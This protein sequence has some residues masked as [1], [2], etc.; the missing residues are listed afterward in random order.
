MKKTP[1]SSIRFLWVM[2]L[3]FLTFILFFRYGRQFALSLDDI[4]SRLSEMTNFVPFRTICNYITALK[5]GNISPGLVL[6]NIL[7]NFV[8]FFPF[9][10]LLPS[11]TNI[12]LRDV[13]PLILLIII[14][15]E[16]LQLITGLG[17]LDVDDLILNF[18]GAV[19]GFIFYLIA[20]KKNNRE[21]RLNVNSWGKQKIKQNKG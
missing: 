18:S 8:L 1:R 14:S 11:A 21:K 10:I 4:K 9:G 6:S 3:I 7:G 19:I 15:V 17:S 13:L 12:R 16:L 20:A 2:Y 5:C